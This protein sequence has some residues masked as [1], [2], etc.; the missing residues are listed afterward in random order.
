M[1]SWKIY[2]KKNRTIGY[3]KKNNMGCG[4]CLS[5][6]ISILIFTGVANTVIGFLFSK[7]PVRVKRHLMPTSLFLPS[8]VRRK[9]I[10]HIV[11]SKQLSNK[12]KSGFV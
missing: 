12:F 1:S 10:E 3:I 2:D 11:G 5:M 8:T 9:Q 7:P 4:G 6:I